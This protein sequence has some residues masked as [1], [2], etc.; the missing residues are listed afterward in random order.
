MSAS[1]L[2]FVQRVPSKIIHGSAASSAANISVVYMYIIRKP[3]TNLTCVVYYIQYVPV[4]TF[5][6]LIFLNLIYL[7][8]FISKN[9]IF[10]ILITHK[11]KKNQK[12]NIKQQQ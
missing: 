11:K 5:I 7:D 2:A 3:A 1:Q 8:S 4:I 9:K 12:P 6:A 10:L